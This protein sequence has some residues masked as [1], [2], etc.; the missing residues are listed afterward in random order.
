MKKPYKKNIF[1]IALTFLFFSYLFSHW[2][3]FKEGLGI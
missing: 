2:D 1:I 3:C